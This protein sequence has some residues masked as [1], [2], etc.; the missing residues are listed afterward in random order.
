MLKLKGGENMRTE[1]ISHEGKIT[2]NTG[3][4]SVIA[5]RGDEVKVVT[6]GLKTWI[7]IRFDLL[8]CVGGA[9]II[10]EVGVSLNGVNSFAEMR[11]GRNDES[12]LIIKQA[13]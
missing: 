2:L 10:E 9:S 7:G 3:E 13:E 11:H 4:A 5:P 12:F 8:T 6:N 1:I